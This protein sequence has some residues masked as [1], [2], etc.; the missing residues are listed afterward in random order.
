MYV[1]SDAR[2]VIV[3]LQNERTPVVAPQIVV[4]AQ[5]VVDDNLCR[6]LTPQIVV[7]H[8]STLYL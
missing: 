5:I 2:C 8:R 6:E 1:E 3:G 7:Y 4:P